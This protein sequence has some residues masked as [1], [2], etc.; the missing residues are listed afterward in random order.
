MF[1]PLSDNYQASPSGSTTPPPPTPATN[2]ALMYNFNYTPRLESVDLN[3]L[4]T[5]SRHTEPSFPSTASYI[6][7]CCKFDCPPSFL[8]RYPLPPPYNTPSLYNYFCCSSREKLLLKHCVLTVLKG[9]PKVLKGKKWRWFLN[10]QHLKVYITL[11]VQISW[12]PW[13]QLYSNPDDKPG[14]A[15]TTE[16]IAMELDT[17]SF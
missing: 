16:R 1:F 10:M 17:A 4:H 3:I 14:F 8:S 12:G 7:F 11:H 5:Q 2:I 6:D 15:E 13:G 9:K